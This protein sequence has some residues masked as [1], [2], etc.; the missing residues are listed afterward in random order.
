L[1]SNIAQ[2]KTQALSYLTAELGLIARTIA[3]DTRI[4]RLQSC[5][6]DRPDAGRTG[7]PNL[8]LIRGM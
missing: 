2:S 6:Q 8:S 1:L 4:Q 7:L 5:T 3:T